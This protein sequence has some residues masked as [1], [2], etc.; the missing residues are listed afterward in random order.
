MLSE[1]RCQGLHDF[2]IEHFTDT[3]TRQLFNL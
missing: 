3:K 2:P 1:S